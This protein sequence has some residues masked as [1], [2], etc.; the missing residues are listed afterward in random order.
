MMAVKALRAAAVAAAFGSAGCYASHERPLDLTAC[1]PFVVS[2]DGVITNA[3]NAGFEVDSVLALRSVTFAWRESPDGARYALGV[4]G[5]LVNRTPLPVCPDT[6]DAVVNVNGA[7]AGL[8]VMGVP[9]LVDGG[10]A[11]CLGAGESA[12]FVA[13]LEATTAFSR[14]E[15]IVGVSLTLGVLPTSGAAVP[16]PE[17]PTFGTPSWHP[18]PDGPDLFEVEVPVTSDGDPTARFGTGCALWNTECGIPLRSSPAGWSVGAGYP[19]AH[20]WVEP[21]PGAEADQELR[22]YAVPFEHR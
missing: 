9:H 13:S 17:A 15:S 14:I 6:E 20:A 8:E 18:S 5:E 11:T 3:P 22:C 19:A 21:D 10:R 1:P 7:G 12:I 4:V 16:D 2:S